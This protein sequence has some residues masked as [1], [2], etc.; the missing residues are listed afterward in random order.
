MKHK[1]RLLSQQKGKQNKSTP[2]KEVKGLGI[3]ESL[4]PSFKKLRQVL[5]LIL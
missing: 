4:D 2:I 3:T 1:F 5:R